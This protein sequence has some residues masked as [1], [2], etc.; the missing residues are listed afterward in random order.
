[1]FKRVVSVF[2]AAMMI[3]ALL[4]ATVFAA[5]PVAT[6]EASKASVKASDSFTV[7]LKVPSVA[8]KAYNASFKVAFDKNVFEVTA[9]TA[10]TI[11]G[12]NLNA[13]S[14]AGEANAA[15][16]VSCSY[17]GQA[18]ENTIDLS[19]GVTMDI[20]FKVKS[21]DSAGVY[22]FIVDSDYTYAIF[23]NEDTFEDEAVFEVASGTKATVTIISEITGELAID[24][25]KPVK[26]ATPQTTV[27]GTGYT[28]AITWSPNDA[29]FGPSTQYTA[30]VELTAEEGYQFANDAVPA[31]NGASTT[32]ILSN[33]GDKLT[34]KAT[35][36]ATDACAHTGGT[37]TCTEQAKCTACGQPYGE[38]AAHVPEADDGDCTTA[39]KC[40]NCPAIVTPAKTAHVAGEDDGDCTTAVKC[41]NCEKNAV[42]AKAAHE[43][44]EDDGDCTTAI[45]CKNCTKDAVEAK[46][47]HVAGE[48][49][50]NCATAVKCVN[51]TKNAIEAGTHVAGE[52]DG[53][54]TTA[55]KCVNCSENAVEAKEKHEAGADDGDCT[56]AIKCKN[57]DKIAVEAK[58]AHEA[59]ADDGDCTTAVK[60]VHCDKNAVEA[61]SHVAGEDDGDCTTAVK[62]QNC[63]KN[64]IEAK[65]VHVA[66]EDDGDCTTAVKCVNCEK[67]AV[68]AKAAHVAGEDDGNCATAVKCVN[69]EKD[70]IAA[71]Q[72][73]WDT[74]WTAGDATHW[75][76]CTNEGCTVKNGE[77]PHN[78]TPECGKKAH[79]SICNA[80]Y[81]VEGGHNF[82]IRTVNAATCIAKATYYYSCSCGAINKE[83][84]TFEDGEFAKHV[85][86][87]EW[88][89][90]SAEHWYACTT[91]GCTEK[92]QKATHTFD[93]SV[94]IADALKSAAN[95]KNAAVY[96]KS[97][98]CGQISTT[99]F[100]TDGEPVA[101]A[102]IWDEGKV[103]KEPT[104]EA[105]GEKTFTCTVDGCGATKVE[106]IAKLVNPTITPVGPKPQQPTQPEEPEVTPSFGDVA[107]EWFEADVEYVAEKG[108]MN[109]VGDGSMFAPLMDTSR[110][111][112]VT[113]L[114]RMEGQPVPKAPAAFT[115]VEKGAYYEQAVAWASENG[116]VN[117]YG[118][119]FGPNDNITREQFAT[120]LFRYAQYKGLAAVTLEENLIGYADHAK[121]S[122]YAVQAMNWAVGKGLIN[123][124]GSEL[125]PAGAASRAQA[126]A[127]LH[128]FCENVIQ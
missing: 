121:V 60:C 35:F 43:A 106:P 18:F 108:L 8:T 74:K 104:T 4:P 59:G 25:T 119:T 16:E 102:H 72:H 68:E 118:A 50:G 5:N 89:K 37:A 29:E 52:D 100:F 117:G 61:K 116:I 11:S 71:K 27:T 66:G 28:G 63:E 53:D 109:G 99:E 20:T 98:V 38:L 40:K 69:C 39:V 62:C 77:Q 48:D 47:K 84:E 10:P 21:D 110:G 9:F 7:T 114:W 3:A 105:E 128:R 17:D 107:G 78:G 34:F 57:C 67:N 15:G 115:D 124:I 56:T 32:Q 42:E 101:D 54:C 14:T 46:E 51:C 112:I 23:Y 87:T 64:A 86:A 81:G 26:G 36:E 41:V 65:A 125:Q 97:C 22:D 31:V 75:Y 24:I 73:A 85:F 19:A 80:D 12:A 33:T 123:G 30:N 96:Y 49:D 93:Q 76:A 83:G 13:A 58:A 92:D 1:M 44:G 94:V 2:V 120:I 70:A 111:M 45:K 55:V 88:S 127:I 82:A 113:I 95:C 126:A 90:D 91:E 6:I 79:C 103:T 122:S